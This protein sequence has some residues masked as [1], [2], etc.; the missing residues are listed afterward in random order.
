MT[1]SPTAQLPPSA[2]V[3]TQSGEK[4]L[5]KKEPFRFADSAR[6]VPWNQRMP[7]CGQPGVL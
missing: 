5:K 1:K 7:R 2:T 6:L 3:Y 4:Q